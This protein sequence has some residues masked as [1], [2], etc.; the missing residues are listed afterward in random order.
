AFGQRRGFLPEIV[1]EAVLPAL[2]ARLNPRFSHNI[3]AK[4]RTTTK[5][6]APV[7]PPPHKPNTGSSIPASVQVPPPPPPVPG[8]AAIPERL[9]CLIGHECARSREIALRNGCNHGLLIDGNPGSLDV[10]PQKLVAHHE[11][12]L[13]AHR[14]E[15]LFAIA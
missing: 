3:P 1:R 12:K 15:R 10:G 13:L 11:G 4:A 7:F 5:A 2:P 9:D 8:G 6:S 14:I